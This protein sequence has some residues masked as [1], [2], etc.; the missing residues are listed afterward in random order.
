ML[1]Q[2]KFVKRK[3]IVNK[4]KLNNSEIVLVNKSNSTVIAFTKTSKKKLLIL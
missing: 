1:K 2:K 4:L 3:S